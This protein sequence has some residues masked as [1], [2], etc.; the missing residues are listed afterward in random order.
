MKRKFTTLLIFTIVTITYS[1][2]NIQSI[3]LDKFIAAN[4]SGT[5]EAISQ[6]IKETYEPNL[7]KKD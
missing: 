5:E 3:I 2:S 6:F 4:N 1:Q 7:Y